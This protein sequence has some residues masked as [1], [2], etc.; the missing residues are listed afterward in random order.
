ME[1]SYDIQKHERDLIDA[2]L[3][4]ERW[5]QKS[6]YE[7]YYGSLM[8]LCMRYADS[9]KDAEDILHE[10][11]IKIFKNIDKYDPGT[12]LKNW[13]VRIVINTAIDNYR[14]REKKKIVELENVYNL[15]VKEPN[16]LQTMTAEEIIASMQQ[17]TQIYRT[18]FNMFVV[19]GYSHKEI[20]ESLNIS[21]STSRSNLVKARKKLKE[22]L[23][24]NDKFYGR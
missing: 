22:I 5:A 21:E 13:M 3:R 6:L 16:A 9:D 18:V 12:S 14:K 7:D 15:K 2:V 19:E 10:S 8:P 20:S 1:R 4:N 17:L 24:S 23:L 11:F